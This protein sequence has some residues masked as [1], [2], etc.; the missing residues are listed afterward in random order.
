MRKRGNWASTVIQKN[1]RSYQ[2]HG[3]HSNVKYTKKRLYRMVA[4]VRVQSL[5]RRYLAAKRTR[6]MRVLFNKSARKIQKVYRGHLCR[7]RL[8]KHWA[9]RRIT[10]FMKTLHFHK[11]KDTVIMIMQLRRLFKKRNALALLIQRVYRGYTGRMYIHNRKMLAIIHRTYSRKIQRAY[12]DHLAR[13]V[14]V[15]WQP[16]GEDWVLEQCGKRLALLLYEMHQ[17]RSRRAE[18]AA[19]Y[20]AAAPAMQ[21]LVRGFISRAGARKMSFLRKAMRSWLQPRLATEFLQQFLSSKV[22]YLNGKG[23]MGSRQGTPKLDL[24]SNAKLVRAFLPPAKQDHFEVDSRSFNKALEL[25]YQSV[26]MP[27]V[28][29]ERDALVRK[30]KNPMNGQ[31]MTRS[32]DAFIFAHKLPCRKHGRFVCG[33]CVF[34]K[35]C[36]VGSCKCQMFKSTTDDG[37]GICANCDHPGT[38]HTLCPLQIRNPFKSGKK[39][40]MLKVLTAV[41]DPDMSLPMSVEGVVVENVIVKPMSPGGRREQRAQELKDSKTATRSLQMT[42]IQERTVG[43]SL[44]LCEVWSGLPPS[45]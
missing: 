5:M 11:F 18:L 28:K 19:M 42:R 23:G 35:N 29:S 34:R 4:T 14:V 2:I 17:D 25:W 33:D 32:L 16:P 15:I 24:I 31:I 26:G 20:R 41:R 3:A 12:R 22:F 43:K 36:N 9:A 37:F 8:Y 27:L 38:L 30:F 7:L 39:S 1:F 45:L 40:S 21:R 13:R 10:K 6:A 44:A